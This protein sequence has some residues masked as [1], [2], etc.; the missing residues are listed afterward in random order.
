MD[1]LGKYI[2]PGLVDIHVHGTNASQMGDQ[3]DEIVSCMAEYLVKRGTTTFVPTISCCA[4]E[5][6]MNNV[7][8][9]KEY[10][11]NGKWG[12]VVGG[13]HLEGPYFSMNYKGAQRPEYIRKPDVTEFREL[14]DASG[15]EIRIISIAPEIPGALEFIEEVS[16]ECVVSIG[17]TDSDYDTAVAAIKKGASHMTHTFNGMRPFKHREPNALGAAFDSNSTCECISDGIHLHPSTVRTLYKIVGSDRLVL[18]TDGC[19]QVGMEDGE[20]TFGERKLIIKDGKATMEDGT[21]DGGCYTLLHNVR[22]AIEFG[23]PVEEAFRCAS[24]N[25]ARV[26]KIEDKVG[27]ID[28]GKNADFLVLDEHYQLCAVYKKGKLVWE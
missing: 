6:L 12:T 19:R 7:Q 24:I 11:K 3:D 25:P 15:G 28:T 23:I 26:L 22:C 20:Y 10:K 14:Q 8:Q 13:I 4:K 9:V 27:S 21:I 1:L 5:T 2:V 16:K 17:H 18:I